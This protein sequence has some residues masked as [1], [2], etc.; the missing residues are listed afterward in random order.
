MFALNMNQ[1]PQLGKVFEEKPG[2]PTHRDNLWAKLCRLKGALWAYWEMFLKRAETWRR[3][4]IKLLIHNINLNINQP[5]DGENFYFPN[6][7][8]AGKCLPSTYSLAGFGYENIF[9]SLCGLSNFSSL[10]Q[11][12]CKFRRVFFV[13]TRAGFTVSSAARNT[14]FMHELA[15]IFEHLHSATE[16]GKITCNHFANSRESPLIKFLTALADACKH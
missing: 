2:K 9:R 15:S 1:P 13:D 12:L 5:H 8:A 10:I 6:T 11:I 4:L 16:R 3:V 7:S 14:Q